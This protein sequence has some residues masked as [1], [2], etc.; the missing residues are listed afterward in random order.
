MRSKKWIAD[1]RR[2]DTVTQ[3]LEGTSFSFA[4][5]PNSRFQFGSFSK[6]TCTF[7]VHSRLQIGSFFTKT[8]DFDTNRRPFSIS[9]WFVLLETM[10]FLCLF[11][12]FNLLGEW[13]EALRAGSVAGS[14]L[15]LKD[16]PL[17]IYIIGFFIAR[18]W[19]SRQTFSGVLWLRSASIQPRKDHSNVELESRCPGDELCSSYG[20]ESKL[21]HR[22]GFNG[23]QEMR[24]RDCATYQPMQ[25]M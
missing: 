18:I 7:G 21:Q 3:K 12:I 5:V 20:E 16:P 19:T 25:E 22:Q 6:Q 4:T 11:T 8:C 14:L 10:W 13:A 17:C 1:P 9:N 2:H 23:I 15:G 24:P